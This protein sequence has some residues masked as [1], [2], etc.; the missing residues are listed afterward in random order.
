MWLVSFCRLPGL[1]VR[2]GCAGDADEGA[3]AGHLNVDGDVGVNEVA[4]G[5]GAVAEARHRQGLL[6]GAGKSVRGTGSV[7][8]QRLILVTSG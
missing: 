8:R 6:S 5:L 7:T 1:R 4:P 3:W 2:A